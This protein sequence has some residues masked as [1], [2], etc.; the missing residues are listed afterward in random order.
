MVF[1]ES[2]THDNF[3]ADG[4]E[5]EDKAVGSTVNIYCNVGNKRITKDEW[6][7]GKDWSR[8]IR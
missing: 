2:L 7:D 6:D 3:N 5:K 8:N 1:S 4:T